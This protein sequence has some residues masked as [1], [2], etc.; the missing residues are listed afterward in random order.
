M[1]TVATGQLY[2]KTFNQF[3][4]SWK[5]SASTKVHFDKGLLRRRSASTKICFDE[6]LLQWR[7]ASLKVCFD[8]GLL[9]WRSASTKVCFDEGPLRQ[10]SC[11]DKGPLRPRSA[12]AKVHLTDKRKAITALSPISW[13][14]FVWTRCIFHFNNFR[15]RSPF[16]KTEIYFIFNMLQ[17]C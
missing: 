11:F 15:C 2:H 13:D 17:T 16:W 8:E 3:V 9:Q 1:S 10:R 12:S 5:M 14:F 7:S 6:G 4:Y